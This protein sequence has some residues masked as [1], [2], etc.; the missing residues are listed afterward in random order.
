MT[1]TQTTITNIKTAALAEFDDV[2]YIG[3]GDDATTP[4]VLDTDLLGPVIRKA[5]DETAVKDIPNGTYDFATTL[6]LTEG[7]GSTL[8]ETGLF[9]QSTGGNMLDRSLLTASVDKT[10]SKE[11]SVGLRITVTVTNE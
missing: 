3:L 10:S 4:S 1:I 2:A 6:G 11:L 5:L 8:E 9:E 7:N